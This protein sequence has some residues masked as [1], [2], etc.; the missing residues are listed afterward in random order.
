M[1]EKISQPLVKQSKTIPSNLLGLVCFLILVAMIPL[2]SFFYIENYEEK[3]VGLKFVYVKGNCFQM[4]SP[5]NE[6]GHTSLENFQKI[7]LEDYWISESEVNLMQF[8]NFRP[9]HNPGKF[10]DIT[11][12][13]ETGSPTNNVTL[14]EAISFAAWLSKKTGYDYRIPNEAEWEYACRAGTSTPTFVPLGKEIC[15]FA[16]VAD[17]QARLHLG[18][19]DTFACNDFHPFYY[20]TK[21]TAA[22]PWGLYDMI[23][24]VAEWSLPMPSRALGANAGLALGGSFLS[25]LP[26]ARCGTR[27]IVSTDRGY[28]EIGFRLIRSGPSKWSSFFLFP[29]Q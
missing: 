18:E 16:M 6:I 10:R 14:E 15:E 27:Q 21:V 8:R 19:S 24:N 26:D 29:D 13:Q 25:K 2:I 5:A 9:D 11:L 12:T 4:G 20:L 23:G 7:C 17:E 22:N 3:A 28:P 1:P